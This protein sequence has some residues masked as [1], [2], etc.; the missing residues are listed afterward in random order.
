MTAWLLAVGPLYLKVPVS[1]LLGGPLGL[2]LR[3][4]LEQRREGASG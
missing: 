4:L 2:E 1:H 3:Q